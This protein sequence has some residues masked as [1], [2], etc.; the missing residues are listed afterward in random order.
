MP[1]K[2]RNWIITINNYDR[3][4]YETLKDWCESGTQ[5]SYAVLAKE[6]GEECKT[7]HI[8]GYLE[9]KGA[10]TLSWFKKQPGLKNCHAESRKGTSD[11]A[12][13]YCKKDGDWWETGEP[14]RPTGV[15][16]DLIQIQKDLDEGKSLK[17][18]SKTYFRA[19]CQYGRRFRAYAALQRD[20]KRNWVT[21]TNVIW[22]KTGTGK[23][24]FVYFMHPD[25]DIWVYPG[26]GWFDNYENQRVVLFDDF[27]GDMDI[28][29]LL[30]VLD[31]Y[32]MDVPTKGGHVNWCPKRI[33]ITSN[34]VPAMWYES[35]D[36]ETRA[37]LSRRFQRIDYVD[38]NLFE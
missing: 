19:W 13:A 22:G 20:V 27:R 30:R 17:Y 10:R 15:R 14:K 28:D 25:D 37:A 5:V 32:P 4:T 21:Y 11:D 9:L 34:I 23:T 16:S 8:Q 12:I 2:H 36:S 3:E 33:Y 1:S 24:R 29:L 6:V 26:R 35:I 38:Y 7:P 18:V 31:R